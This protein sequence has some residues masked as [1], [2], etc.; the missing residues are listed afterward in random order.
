[1]RGSIGTNTSTIIDI[2]RRRGKPRPYDWSLCKG[3]RKM[4]GDIYCINS[5]SI[6][7]VNKKTCKYY[8]GPYQS[9]KKIKGK[10]NQENDAGYRKGCDYGE[11]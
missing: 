11:R 7:K 3:G 4:D 6:Q 8:S 5:G 10:G 2:R 9:R 1:M